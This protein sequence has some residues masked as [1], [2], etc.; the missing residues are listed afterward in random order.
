MN[1]DVRDRPAVQPSCR[2]QSAKGTQ[3]LQVSP[4]V[5]RS[6]SASIRKFLFY[7]DTFHISP[8]KS[9]APSPPPEHS[10]ELRVCSEPR[11]A[12]RGPAEGV[13]QP[14]SWCCS[15]C[16]GTSPRSS[17]SCGR[18]RRASLTSWGKGEQLSEDRTTADPSIKC[19]QSAGFV[20]IS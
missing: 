14:W 17:A 9:S 1:R 12:W 10:S 11:R 20:V 4:K 16:S 3:S 5:T 19:K 6:P 8:G 18:C 7:S 15:R 13:G 2:W